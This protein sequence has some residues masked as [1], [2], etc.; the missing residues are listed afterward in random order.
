MTGTKRTSR[1]PMRMEV[2]N[3]K[4]GH[5]WQSKIKVLKDFEVVSKSIASQLTRPVGQ[6]V[7][8]PASH[9]G[10]GGSIPRCCEVL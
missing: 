7:K 10:N 8:T 5:I 9:A 3:R 2:A 1:M 4:E 6:A